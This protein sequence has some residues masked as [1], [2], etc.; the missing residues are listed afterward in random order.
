MTNRE[1]DVV[2]KKQPEKDGLGIESAL[3]KPATTTSGD[4]YKK[5]SEQLQKHQITVDLH[6]FP[7]SYSAY[8]G[9]R[10]PGRVDVQRAVAVYRRA[11]VLLAAVY[12]CRG[13]GGAAV[14][15]TECGESTAVL[16]VRLPCPCLTWRSHLGLPR[17]LQHSWQRPAGHTVCGRREGHQ[18]RDQNR[19]QREGLRRVEQ[20]PRGRHTERPAVHLVHRRA[21]A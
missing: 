9:A 1:R 11:V 5:L 4:Y 7:S 12:E 6:F 15:H 10:L 16:R 20:G 19:R 2:E 17:P 13:E 14:D 8:L 18:L 3:L 21:D